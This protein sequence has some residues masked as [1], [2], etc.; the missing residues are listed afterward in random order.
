M[1]RQWK[2]LEL[3]GERI[4]SMRILEL[5]CGIGAV[6][7]LFADMGATVV[8]LEGRVENVLFANEKYRDIET[9]QVMHRNICDGFADLGEFDLI[10]NFGFFE[11][12]RSAEEVEFVLDDSAKISSDM[13]IETIVCDLPDEKVRT[14]EPHGS[15]DGSIQADEGIVPSIKL[16]EDHMHKL[17]YEGEVQLDPNLNTQLHKYDLPQEADKQ[18]SEKYRR[19][20]RFQ[21]T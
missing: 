15:G 1:R 21:R 7:S 16:I 14:T 12:L 6:G 3:I 9:Y 11:V 2:V 18:G 10:L 20:W 5:G 19:F 17:G 13:L 8:G 4:N